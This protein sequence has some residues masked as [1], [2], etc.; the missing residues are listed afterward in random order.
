MGAYFL[1]SLPI[2]YSIG[3]L[4]GI[5]LTK[6]ED[7]H[8]ALWHKVGRLP[9]ALGIGADLIKGAVP[10]LLGKA[11]S[12]D[13][14]VVALAGLLVVVGQ[15]WPVFTNFNG[16][17][18]NTTGITMIVSLVA[19]KPL[20]AALVPMAAG[21]LVRTAPRLLNPK[22]SMQERLK[23]GGPPS[24]SMPLG[25][26]AGFAVLPLST[27]AFH[28]PMGETLA[29]LALF[30]LIMVRRL[31]AALKPDLKKAKDK[32]VSTTSVLVN[33]LLFDRSFR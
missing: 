22:Q 8:I 30:L 33:R 19:L 14:Q 4:Y 18:G 11:L 24:L 29:L 26:A 25:M 2:V 9:G 1:G 17:K 20:L 31:T 27:W 12:F 15:M 32:R 21:I 5:D 13:I 28:Q 6:E 10:V 23:L 7:A 16:G 3:K